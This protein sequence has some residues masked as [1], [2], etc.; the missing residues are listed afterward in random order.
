MLLDEVLAVQG[1]AQEVSS[2]KALTEIGDH[3]VLNCGITQITSVVGS[4][5]S[6]ART[7]LE[8]LRIDVG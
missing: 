4:N 3:G 6:D 7:R 2:G 5:Q 1:D 8:H